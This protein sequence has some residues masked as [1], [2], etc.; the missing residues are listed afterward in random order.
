MNAPVQ[1]QG[2]Q[3]VML[4]VE[5]LDDSPTNPRTAYT[6]IEELGQSMR[7]SGVI[8]PLI[9]R[10][11]GE[12]FELAAGHRRKRG[13]IAA[14]LTVVPC[15][16]RHYSDEQIIEA[17]L[18]ENIQRADIEP[19][20]EGESYR[21]L[22]SMGRTID[23]ICDRVGKSRSWV[24]GRVKLCGL[25]EP[26]KNALAAGKISASVALLIARRPAEDQEKALH[27]VM[28]YEGGPAWSYREAVERL[29]RFQVRLPLLHEAPFHRERTTWTSGLECLPCSECPKVAQD[30]AGADIC[31]DASCWEA[32]TGAHVEDL[33]AA[34]EAAGGVALTVA[35]SRGVFSS[36]GATKAGWFRLDKT[37]FDV[38]DTKTLE[39]ALGKEGHARC[40]HAVRG[41]ELVRVISQE[42]LEAALTAQG[43]TTELAAVRRRVA[44]VQ[45]SKSKPTKAEIEA[46][47]RREREEA[48]RR[49]AHGATVRAIV[50]R[51]EAGD[52]PSWLY[53]AVAEYTMNGDGAAEACERRGLKPP[54]WKT[55]S[56]DFRRGLKKLTPLQ[57][58]A[59]AVDSM[60]GDEYE[61]PQLL[62]LE[63]AKRRRKGGAS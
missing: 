50:Q 59:L 44:R 42:K 7:E 4:P 60:L 58:F 17:Q 38:S 13:A 41:H 56:A 36:V 2:E 34:V 25:I 61:G 37:H 31:T 3:I 6:G 48:Q 22:M 27:A 62:E 10:P 51:I 21:R 20:D 49:E 12:R 23:Q 63:P 40:V 47:E 52:V 53:Y 28:P 18:I 35:K 15:V 5:L 57:A 8:Q 33:R 19:M 11:V 14:G 39:K 43:K 9:V 32:K 30:A 26:G 29:E 46:K 55:T 54:G 45:P 24:Y 16:V 1:P